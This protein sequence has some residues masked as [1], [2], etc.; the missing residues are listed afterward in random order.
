MMMPQF[1]SVNLLRQQCFNEI[2]LKR[3]HS[4]LALCDGILFCETRC[5][6]A[7]HVSLPGSTGHGGIY[8]A[9]EKGLIDGPNLARVILEA[10]LEAGHLYALD[11]TNILRP[12]AKTSPRRKRLH[13]GG[14]KRGVHETKQ[15]WSFSVLVKLTL[16]ED[17]FTIPVSVREVLPGED[18]VEGV[19]LQLTELVNY[20]HATK[21]NPDYVLFDAGFPAA[22]LENAI[23]K[24]ALPIKVIV[25]LN[26]R[27]VF[28]GRPETYRGAGRPRVHGEKL[29]LKLPALPPDAEI[30]FPEEVFGSLKVR[31]WERVHPKT[32]D[33]G[34]SEG[35]VLLIDARHLRRGMQR[36]QMALWTSGGARSGENALEVGGLKLVELLTTYLRRFDIE[37]LFRLWKHHLGLENYH[38]KTPEQFVRWVQCFMIVTLEAYLGK[39]EVSNIRLPWERRKKISPLRALRGLKPSGQYLW[40][41]AQLPKYPAPGPRSPRGK[42]K[43]KRK[44]F[45]VWRPGRDLASVGR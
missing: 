15:G 34:V 22:R 11:H 33:I 8:A 17:S 2:F 24:A 39:D 7:G 44:T 45:P 4:L 30:S 27:Q 28:Y 10:T 41:P 9:L 14:Y 43:G 3:P 42:A 20:S 21:H 40:S 23:K 32:P 37:H 1:D 25:R 6:C 38:P 12:R 16:K 31:A 29:S 18:I 13:Q 35:T 26:L 36:T 5:R 19:L